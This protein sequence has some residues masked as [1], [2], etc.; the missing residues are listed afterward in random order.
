MKQRNKI[1]TYVVIVLAA[2]ICALNYT[3]FV[4]PNR[5]APAGI[6]G[7]CTM[8]QHITG[9]NMGYLSLLLNIPLAIAVYFCVSKTLAVRAFTY[10]ALFSGFL[11]VLEKVDLSA[12]VYSTVNGTS[13]IM[14]PLVAGIITGAVTTLLLRAGTYTGGTD[15][16]AS[17]IHKNRPSF[18]F[19]WISFTLNSVVALVSYFVYGYKIEPVLMC[20]LYSFAV[21]TVMDKMNRAGRSAIR[22]EI[23]TRHPEELSQAIIHK[24]HHSATLIPGKGIY[25]GEEVSVL[26]CV[27]NKSQVAQVSNIIRAVPDTFAVSDIVSEVIGN[28]KHL[29]IN[30]RQEISFLD[31]GEG[32]GI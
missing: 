31:P 16:V 27:V 13:T 15:F 3:V 19:F 30:G 2:F 9:L 6:N 24:L 4:L 32:T 23:I 18:N 1:L 26:I 21:S 28:F 12:I 5:F 7:I 17:L 8:F 22:F 10:A 29:D 14:G 11:L 20:I 25:R